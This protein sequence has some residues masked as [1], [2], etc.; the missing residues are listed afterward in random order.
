MGLILFLLDI[1][2]A[3]AG[4]LINIGLVLLLALALQRLFQLFFKR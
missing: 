2:L 1:A 4:L 3:L